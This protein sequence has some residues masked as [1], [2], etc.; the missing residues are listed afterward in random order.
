MKRMM[1]CILKSLSECNLKDCLG[2]R[3]GG[4]VIVCVWMEKEGE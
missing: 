2:V 3:G 1:N 4:W